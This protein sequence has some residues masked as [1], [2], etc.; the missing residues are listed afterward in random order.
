MK[1]RHVSLIVATRWRTEELKRLLDSLLVQ[2]YQVF[3][4]IIVDQN[5]DDRLVSLVLQFAGRLTIRHVRSGFMASLRQII[6]VLGCVKGISSP[7]PMTI[8]GILQ[9]FAPCSRYV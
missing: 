2:T 9:S 4:V 3:E 5:E 8:V 6:V 7:F 1:P